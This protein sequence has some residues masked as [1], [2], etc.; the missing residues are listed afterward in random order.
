MSL[1]SLSIPQTRF[2][3]TL[4]SHRLVSY[5]KLQCVERSALSGLKALRILS[6]QGNDVSQIPDGAFEDLRDIT[7]IALGSNPLYC[8]CGLRWLS[9][10]VKGDYVEPG[11]A[12]CAEPRQLKDK[13]VLTTPSSKFTCRGA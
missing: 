11:I 3:T 7:H 2:L 4:L 5:N 10:W 13:L 6:L 12:R 9:D 1:T 8:D